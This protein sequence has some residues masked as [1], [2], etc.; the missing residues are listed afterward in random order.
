MA[1]YF[2]SM[3]FLKASMATR[4]ET[5][6]DKTVIGFTGLCYNRGFFIDD[7]CMIIFLVYAIVAVRV[8][9]VVKAR[10]MA[11]STFWLE[12]RSE[13]CRNTSGL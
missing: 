2:Q 9:V 4:H 13:T 8:V 1:G 7:F 6:H 12:N 3:S 11:R 5:K 10:C